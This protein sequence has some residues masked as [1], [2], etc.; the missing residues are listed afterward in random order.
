[1]PQMKHDEGHALVPSIHARDY[2]AQQRAKEEA[3]ARRGAREEAEAARRRREEEQHRRNIERMYARQQ[4]LL[5]IAVAA[6]A[7]I[8]LKTNESVRLGVPATLHRHDVGPA[9][10]FVSAIGNERTAYGAAVWLGVH[11]DHLRLFAVLAP[12]ANQIEPDLAAS[13]KRRGIRVYVADDRE[14]ARLLQA[15]GNWPPTRLHLHRSDGPLNSV[16][17]ALRHLIAD[18]HSRITT[19]RMLS[20]WRL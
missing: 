16:D 15:L 10:N 14:A 11:R 5:P 7:R 12:A 13:W 3:A 6:A 4:H 9:I 18:K 19:R 20:Q 8:A 2:E 1:L 17:P